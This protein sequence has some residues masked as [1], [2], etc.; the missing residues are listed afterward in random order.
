[1]QGL[2]L[3]GDGGVRRL[4]FFVQLHNRSMGRGLVAVGGRRQGR[5]AVSCVM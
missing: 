5:Q 3:V 1:M 2:V 4:F